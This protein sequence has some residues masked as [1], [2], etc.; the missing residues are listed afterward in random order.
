[1]R[2]G[3]AVAFVALLVV[4]VVIQLAQVKKRTPGD[5]SVTFGAREFQVVKG[6]AGLPPS[7]KGW[8]VRASLLGGKDALFFAQL[9]V[10]MQEDTV[11]VDALASRYQM[12]SVDLATVEAYQREVPWFAEPANAIKSMW[13]D[14]GTSV[15]FL[16]TPRGNIQSVYIKLTS[17]PSKWPAQIYQL[18]DH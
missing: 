11:W 18:F 1:M 9:E 16:T 15:I 10:A 13:V 4:V 17:G 12:K 2:T 14:K 8:I 7:L 5:R 3:I 6:A